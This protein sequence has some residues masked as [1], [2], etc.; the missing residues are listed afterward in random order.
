MNILFYS[1]LQT[2]SK[3]TESIMEAFVKHGESVYLLTQYSSEIYH[4]ACVPLGVQ[5]FSTPI[6]GTEGWYRKL[7]QI[8]FLIKFCK[9]KKIDIIYAQLEP[10]NFI[11]VLA[12]YFI[13]SKVV[14]VR[15]HV[16]LLE[17]D[18]TKL[19]H[20]IS[21]LTYKL[22]R[23]SVVVSNKAKEYMVSREG[24]R[25]DKIKKI[26][27]G[28]NFALWP[29]SDADFV[30][31]KR[32][33][34]KCDFV[35][36]TAARLVKSKRIDIVFHIVKRLRENGYNCGLLLLGD[37]DEQE[38][39][40]RLAQELRITDYIFFEGYVN[41][42]VD[43]VAA[44]DMMIHLSWTES[45]ATVVKEA[46]LARKPVVVCENVGDF[47]DYIVEGV[48]GFLVD[49]ES[50]MEMAIEKIIFYITNKNKFMHLGDNLYASVVNTFSIDSI[51]DEYDEM[52][53]L[54]K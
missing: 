19:A 50:P 54:A 14:L 46:G 34:L 6:I 52:N 31:Q 24:I 2:R 18:S 3:D 53:R 41:N 25:P 40:K 42:V 16:D 38:N 32:E 1:P 7:K 8:L 36:V 20:W 13:K 5:C 33:S 12:Q 45:S 28:F 35:L 29:S 21:I 39:L 15:H 44:S 49:R 27:L 22:S 48:N 10:A 43:Y 51:Y 17:T 47:S 30:K 23:N 37:G 11:A 9:K 4:A 26:N